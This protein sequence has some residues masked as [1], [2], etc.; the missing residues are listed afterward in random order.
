MTPEQQAAHDAAVVSAQTRL[1]AIITSV[2]GAAMPALAQHLAFKTDLP[3]ETCLGALAAATADLTTAGASV[4]AGPTDSAAGW[5]S[6][7]DQANGRFNGGLGFANTVGGDS[8][9]EKVKAGW[10]KAVAASN[11]RFQ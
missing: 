5:N 3:A 6:A 7:V 2:D 4:A 11:A 1:Q 9:A 8:S 10:S